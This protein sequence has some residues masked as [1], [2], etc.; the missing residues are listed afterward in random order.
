MC[1]LYF[2]YCNL[3]F[4]EDF[5]HCP[6]IFLHLKNQIAG[7]HPTLKDGVCS[8]ARRELLDLENSAVLDQMLLIK[9]L[10]ITF[11]VS[12]VIL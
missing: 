2:R 3:E 9:R 8:A 1:V 10:E 4:T 7:D 12:S 5:I 6:Q 11:Y